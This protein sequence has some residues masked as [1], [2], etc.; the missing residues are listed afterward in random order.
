MFERLDLCSNVRHKKGGNLK[1][2][3]L[4]FNFIK[5]EMEGLLLFNSVNS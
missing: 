4:V 1:I 2:I 3:A 5:L